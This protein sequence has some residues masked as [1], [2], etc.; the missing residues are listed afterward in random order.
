MRLRMDRFTVLRVRFAPN[1]QYELHLAVRL[2]AFTLVLNV[3]LP[4]YFQH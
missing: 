1:L 2:R 4:R 3:R